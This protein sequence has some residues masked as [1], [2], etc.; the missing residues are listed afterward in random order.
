MADGRSAAVSGSLND[1]ARDVL[2]GQAL[3]AGGKQQD[4]AAVDGERLHSD[5][6]LVSRRRRHVYIGQGD[7]L[8]V[9]AWK[10][11]L[12]GHA[13]TVGITVPFGKKAP[14]SNV[15]T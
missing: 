13:V 8:L 11:G 5:E 2:A 3:T 7:Q 4:L 15:G 6:Y 14:E 12:D 10:E 1:A 9:T